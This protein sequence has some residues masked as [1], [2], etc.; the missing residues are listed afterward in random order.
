M[1]DLVGTNERGMVH[2]SWTV[3]STARRPHGHVAMRSRT[4]RLSCLIL[5][6]TA[7]TCLVQYTAGLR[8]IPIP[9][10]SRLPNWCLPLLSSEY[11]GTLR[12]WGRLPV[13]RIRAQRSSCENKVIQIR[14]ENCL[15]CPRNI[16]FLGNCA[17]QMPRLPP[18]VA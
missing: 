11:P 1:T 18:K 5:R 2:H 10:R 3:V 14:H 6:T 9:M 13:G 7:I 16:Q 17:K 15:A 8:N 12:M 4:R